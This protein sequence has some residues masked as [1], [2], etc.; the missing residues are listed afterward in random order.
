M[1]KV[2]MDIPY[3]Q[4]DAITER[5][6]EHGI[7]NFVL[8]VP[9]DITTDDNGY[10]IAEKEDSNA[11]LDLYYEGGKEDLMDFIETVKTYLKPFELGEV[12]HAYYD[13]CQ[14]QVTFDDIDLGNGWLITSDPLCQDTHCI[15]L[16][17]GGAFGTGLHETTREC[18][19]RLLKANLKG[20]RILDIGTG[21]GILT[22][23]ALI[24]GASEVT[25]VDVRD[26]ED[27]VVENIL[28][29]YLNPDKVTLKTGYYNSKLIPETETF[30]WVIVNIGGDE[31]IAMLEDISKHLSMGGTLLV[32]GLVDWNDERVHKVVSDMGFER[33]DRAQENEWVT[34]IYEFVT[35]KPM[36]NE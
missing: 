29:N 14:D 17:A 13:A 22:I 36:N 31:T 34:M 11:A 1:Y 30:D 25:A 12:R 18:L 8:N 27:E 16:N 35:H 10:G 3:R 2:T 28:M 6:S 32:S 4:S 9:Y 7:F 15:R 33:I 21:S 24:S 19:R 23:G 20:K 26:V 5:L